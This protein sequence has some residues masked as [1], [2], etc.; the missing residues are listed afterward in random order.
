[1]LLK[2]RL[3][4]I[5]ILLLIICS[6]ESFADQNLP[7]GA[8]AVPISE[9]RATVIET[10]HAGTVPDQRKTTTISGIIVDNLHRP[11]KDVAVALSV[12]PFTEVKTDGSGAFFLKDVPDDGPVALEIWKEGFFPLFTSIPITTSE[13]KS[14]REL[15]MAPIPPPVPI[16]VEEPPKPQ[17]DA[18]KKGEEDK[19]GDKKEPVKADNKI[20]IEADTLSYDQDT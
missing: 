2:K 17:V 19:K 13:Q 5:T 16:P 1:M 8:G 9:D 3:L 12:F 11:L 7:S 4:Y 15:T 6:I 20:H 18:G 10:S 14:P